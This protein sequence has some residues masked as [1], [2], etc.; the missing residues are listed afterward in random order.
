MKVI[1][2]LAKNTYLEIIR[3]RILYVLL[4]FSLLLIGLSLA[5]GE[6][7]F[8]EQARISA[9]FGFTAIHLSMV[10]L[11]VFVGS[12]LVAREIDKKTILTLLVRPILR[13]EFLLGKCLGLT[14][15]TLT[16]VVGLALVLIGVFVA[17]KVPMNIQ[18]A[19]ALFGVLLE[20]F[21][22]LGMTIF[23]G[24]F[25]SPTMAVAFSI[26]LF[27]IGHWLND[28]AF[29]AKK[30]EDSA[31]MLFSDFAGTVIPNLEKFNWRSAVIYDETVGSSEFLAAA[32]Y[33]LAWFTL[34][35]A[36]TS[37]VFRRKDF[38]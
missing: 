26:G 2:I 4:V 21:V 12:T 33:S 16:V 1:W 32:G 25:A 28:L 19:V 36:L 15:V 3:D 18:F 8:A 6:L 17:L 7:S 38:V 34:F 5:L 30:S 10:A 20:S 9:N 31:F 14:M 35:I 23:F 11:S 22:L 13:S 29:F 27:L 24:S 37:W